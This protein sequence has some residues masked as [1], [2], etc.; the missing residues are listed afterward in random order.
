MDTLPAEREPSAY[1]LIASGIERGIPPDQMT[2]LY[3]IYREELSRKAETAFNRDFIACQAEMPVLIKN[4][5]GGKANYIE[6]PE[7]L[8]LCMPV[9]QS[10]GFAV[11]FT[12]ADC[13][14]PDHTRVV[15]TV[16]HREGHI[17]HAQVD[18]AKDG[19]GAKGGAVA[20]N[21]SQASGSTYSYGQRYA[22]GK[23]WNL[24]FFGEDTDAATF[25]DEKQVKE[26]NTLL[27]EC[28]K[29]GAAVDLA[30]FLKWAT[31]RDDAENVGDISRRKFPE[32][33]QILT[34]KRR[35]AQNG[36]T[37]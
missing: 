19:K 32:A 28:E 26:I 5:K 6:M 2:A 9:C 34:A 15:M 33:V 14:L 37:K 12:T 35:K 1:A 3:A 22:F 20:M 29:A 21:D 16:R 24:R 7:I 27:D 13:P 4:K 30:A 10:H 23:Y 36:A 18:V 25:I 17:D 11:S 8:D 31:G